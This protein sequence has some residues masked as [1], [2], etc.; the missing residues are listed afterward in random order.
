MPLL[1]VCGAIDPLLP[2]S[3]N[4]VEQIYHAFS[5]RISVM[6]KEGA[7]HHPHSSSDPS[8]IADFLEKSQEAARPAPPDF[9]AGRV[10]HASFYSHKNTY[11]FF[12]KEQSY[13][14]CRGPASGGVAARPGSR[15]RA[16]RAP[17]P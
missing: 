17:S 8:P 10:T 9:A 12:Q 16:W 13:I 14:T 1:H 5:R 7:G 3:S 11:R 6:V 2:R 4:A 15:P